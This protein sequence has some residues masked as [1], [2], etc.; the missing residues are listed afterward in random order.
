[1]EAPRRL[2]DCLQLLSAHDALILLRNCFALPRLL[3]SYVLHTAPCFRSA[4]LE[5]YDNCLREI[6]GGVT[7]TLLERDSQAWMQ[8]TLPV[9]LGGLGIGSSVISV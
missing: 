8:T 3:Y 7:N 1:M 2:G 6:L 5:T 9:K 4:T